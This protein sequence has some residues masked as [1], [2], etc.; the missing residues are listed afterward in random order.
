ME[1]LRKHSNLDVEGSVG[2]E[3]GLVSLKGSAKCLYQERS[4]VHEAS[5]NV[6][7]RSVTRMRFIPMETLSNM[8]Y[9]RLLDD[10]RVTHFVAKVVEGGE[11]NIRFTRQCGSSDE[12]GKIAGMLAGKLRNVGLQGKG[13]IDWGEDEKKQFENINISVSGVITDP[14]CSIEDAA[15]LARKLPAKLKGVTNTLEVVLLP[16]S[17]LDHKVRK[18]VRQLDAERLKIA[19]QTLHDAQIAQCNV[20]T[21]TEKVSFSALLK[22]RQS[23]VK[24][25][26]KCVSTFRQAVCNVLPK[27][28]DGEM[29]QPSLLLVL[30][31]AVQTMERQIVVCKRFCVLKQKEDVVLIDLIKLLE[32]DGFENHLDVGKERPA[33]VAG[34]CRAS[35]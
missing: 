25:M 23:F 6:T 4:D 11:V 14:V 3:F 29:D 32:K 12:Q 20:N 16:V 8:R 9:S 21:A 27:L 34:L 31:R 30:D 17:L 22:Q 35:W 13:K 28:K 7:C 1:D 19:L 26:T 15:V 33:L 18:V 24:T 10:S 5:V 2:V